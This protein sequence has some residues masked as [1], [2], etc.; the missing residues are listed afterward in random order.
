M[1]RIACTSLVF[2]LLS[3]C[4]SHTPIATC[5]AVVPYDEQTQNKAADEL[6]QLVG[7]EP[8][9]TAEQMSQRPRS[10]LERLMGDYAELR[11]RLRRCQ[12]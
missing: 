5:P 12:P 2:L 10:T 11:S 7:L 8:G 9:C 4:A 3:A 6:C 1:F